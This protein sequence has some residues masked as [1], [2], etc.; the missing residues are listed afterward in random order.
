MSDKKP[1]TRESE[2]MHREAIG[3]TAR[4]L[5]G[6]GAVVVVV[7]VAVIVWALTRR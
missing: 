2:R 1:W 6:C 3:A 7:V 5:V 4:N